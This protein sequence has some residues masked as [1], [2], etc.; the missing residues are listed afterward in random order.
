VGYRYIGSKSA[1]LA[2]ILH[3]I[4]SV[5][6][7]GSRIADLMCGTASVSA[8]LRERGYCVTANDVM[9]YSFHHA[10][11]ALLFNAPPAF[12]AAK[13]FMD[14]FCP[15]DS[16]RLFPQAPY[17][18]M[19]AALNNV[20]EER[21][22]FWRE[23]CPEG[24]PR[25]TDKP[26]CYF[27]PANARKIDAIRS[28]LRRLSE[29][30]HMNDM[31]RSLLLH[32]LVMAVN[33]V[34][35]IAGTYGHYM[36]K[37]SGRANDPLKLNPSSLLVRKDAGKHAVL[38]GYAEEVASQIDC[39]LCYIDPPYMKRQYAANYHILET[40]AREDEPEAVGVSGL[41]PWRD[42]YSNFCTKTRIWDSFRSI[43]SQMPCRHFL[44]SYSEDGLLT[45]DQLEGLFS[46]FGEV[47][48]HTFAH[49][50]FRSNNSNLTPQLTEYA[51]HLTKTRS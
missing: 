6:S 21:G 39:D 11:V 19:L 33:D 36:A 26:R 41:R 40:I 17:E 4:E 15:R 34:A 32:D 24:Q 50:R 31:E 47:R 20:P 49:K 38:Q 12:S 18:R 8:A 48:T 35:N 2:K 42:Q 14:E 44:V 28:W 46:E 3:H 25:N 9:T 10:R 23:Y 7:A 51:I 13:G 16:E 30:R 27:S 29:A 45:L 43:F 1:L 22:Y 37:L 5:V